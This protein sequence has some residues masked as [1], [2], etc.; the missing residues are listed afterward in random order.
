MIPLELV[1]QLFA[2]LIIAVP[3]LTLWWALR[4]HAGTDREES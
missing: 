1:A 3:A 4:G 2:A